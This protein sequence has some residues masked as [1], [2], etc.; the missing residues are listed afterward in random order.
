LSDPRK[1]FDRK[2]GFQ[3]TINR[4]NAGLF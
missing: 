4:I 1:E 2:S 3:R